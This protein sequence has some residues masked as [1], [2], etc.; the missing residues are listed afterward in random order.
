MND[1]IEV[2]GEISLLLATTGI[3]LLLV[4]LAICIHCTSEYTGEINEKLDL[5][6]QK[7]KTKNQKN[8]S[9]QS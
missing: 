5:V 8:E 3:V 2:A 9:I 1:V 7:L 4:Y 6:I